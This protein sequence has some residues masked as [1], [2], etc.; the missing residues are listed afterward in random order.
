MRAKQHPTRN[1]STVRKSSG[2]W[3]DAVE[4]RRLVIV[5]ELKARLEMRNA[6]GR[7]IVTT[8]DQ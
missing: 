3:I 6:D 7:L 8:I 1:C 2:I 4:K 5:Y